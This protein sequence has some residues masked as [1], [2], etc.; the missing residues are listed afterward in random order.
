MRKKYNNKSN[1]ITNWTVSKLKKMHRE[2]WEAIEVS[3]SY[4][5]RDIFLMEF[6]AEELDKRGWY[7]VP[8]IQ[9]IKKNE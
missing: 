5:T 7:I 4:G 8:I 1:S 9:F 2:V 6:L 3:D